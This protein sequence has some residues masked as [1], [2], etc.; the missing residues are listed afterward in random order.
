MV[1]ESIVNLTATNTLLV[2]EGKIGIWLDFPITYYRPNVHNE[3]DLGLWQILG[4]RNP[5][6]SIRTSVKLV[7]S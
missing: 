3:L 6:S 4:I 5:S 7:A 1:M 2:E